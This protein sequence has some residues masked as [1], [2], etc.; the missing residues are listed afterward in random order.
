MRFFMNK[1]INFSLDTENAEKNYSLANWYENQGHTA[2]A[3]TYYLRAAERSDDKILAYKSLLR[4]SFCYRSQ[5]SRDATERVL[6]ENALNLL[7]ERPEAYYFLSLFYERKEDWQSCYSF[8]N[9]GLTQYKVNIEKIDI[10]EY[11]GKHY[12]IFQKAFSSWW[13]GKGDES[14]SLTK[15]LIE[16]YWDDLDDHRKQCIRSNSFLI[17]GINVDL[18][19]E[20]SFKYPEDFNWS[21]LPYEDICTI[22]REI[23][24]EK[25]YRFWSDVNKGDTVLDIGASVGAYTISILDQ[26]PKK[27]YCVEPSKSFLKELSKN[28]TE[29]LI[30]NPEVSITY[31]NNGIVNEY[32][33]KISVFGDDKSFVPITFKEM[34]EKYSISNINFMKVDCEGGEYSIFT[35]EN[36][37]FLTTNVDFISMEIHLKGDGFR[38]KFK[39]LRDNYLNRFKE[40]KLMSC[41]RQNISWGNTLDL[42]HK[43]FDDEFIDNYNCELMLYIDNRE[44]NSTLQSRK[45]FFD[46]GTH[47]FQ[48]FEQIGEICKVDHNWECYC[49]EANAETYLKSKQKYYD[50]LNN[51]FNI[52]HFNVA[53]LDRNTNLHLNAIESDIW[54]GTEVGTFTSQAS[55]ILENP[56]KECSGKELIYQ[57][58]KHFVRAIDFSSFLSMFSNIND[59]NVV[60]LDIEGSEFAVLDKLILDGT[61]KYINEL[62]I[63]FHPHFFADQEFYKEKITKYKKI[64]N[65]YKIKFTEWF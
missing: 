30:N 20:H 9:L 19:N 42:T 49:F 34:V 27:V 32:T 29:K 37:D 12:L 57:N 46:C 15:L 50:L 60:K 41:T 18:F 31:I 64:F 38:E 61:I 4:A 55:N 51:G 24:D 10:P 23:V 6:L 8:A 63:E 13:W 59:Y 65:E 48:G 5:G 36:I 21:N 17:G 52:K 22:E 45:K 14:R 33:D 53:V 2:P 26:K 47:I 54:D 28:C 3:H 44:K 40:F 43:I 25:V 62:Y 7:P 39:N 56:P 35:D 1:L 11:S 16:N 58:E